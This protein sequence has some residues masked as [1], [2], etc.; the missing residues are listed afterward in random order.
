VN[1]Q[2]SIE[3]HSGILALTGHAS[4]SAEAVDLVRRLIG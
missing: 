2:V 1:H 3:R 4:D